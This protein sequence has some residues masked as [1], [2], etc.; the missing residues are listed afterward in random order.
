MNSQKLYTA[1]KYVHIQPFHLELG[2]QNSCCYHYV[3]ARYE[4]FAHPATDSPLLAVLACTINNHLQ[5]QSKMSFT[6][7]R[8]DTI[9]FYHSLNNLTMLLSL[10]I[11]EYII[12]INTERTLFCI[13]SVDEAEILSKSSTNRSKAFNC[14]HGRNS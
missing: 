11:S 4:T 2:R 13:Y 8:L 14:A 3:I 5:Q 7:S 6:E 12:N 9:L 1:E 10:E